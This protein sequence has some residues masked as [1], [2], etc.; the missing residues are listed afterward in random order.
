MLQGTNH[1]MKLMFIHGSLLSSTQFFAK[2]FNGWFSRDKITPMLMPEASTSTWNNLL[3][4]ERASTGP[5][6]RA[7]VIVSKL[8]DWAAFQLK[9]WIF[10]HFV[11]D[12]III[13]NPWMNR[14]Y[15]LASAW[16]LLTSATYIRICQSWMASTLR[17]STCMPLSETM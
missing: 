11:I 13:L 17:G 1:Y 5:M 12:V 4:S 8:W 9:P 15:K 2:V 7:L 10:R 14:Q 6:L 3:K 16:K